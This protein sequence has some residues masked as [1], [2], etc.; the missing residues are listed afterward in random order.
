MLN[1]GSVLEVV[2]FTLIAGS[3]ERAFLD[4][5]REMEP[6]LARN[7]GYIMREL[8]KTEDGKWVDMVHWESV[9]EAAEAIRSVM[10]SQEGKQ[11]ASMIDPESVTSTQSHSVYSTF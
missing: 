10:Q 5:V 11:F 8:N 3:D 9:D 7:K 1:K 2:L 4:S 6:V